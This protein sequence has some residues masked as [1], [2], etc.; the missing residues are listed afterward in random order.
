[1]IFGRHKEGFERL[2]IVIFVVCAAGFALAHLTAGTPIVKPNSE[3]TLGRAIDA[4]ITQE[5]HDGRPAVFQYMC[6]E[7]VIGKHRLQ[8]LRNQT[9]TPTVV[10]LILVAALAIGFFGIR[11][12]RWIRE[13]FQAD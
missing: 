9:G 6:R 12:Y 13:G 1:M 10:V 2:I 7:G 8:H 11:T 3:S 5:C 4:E